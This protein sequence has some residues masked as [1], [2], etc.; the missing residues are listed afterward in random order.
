MVSPRSVTPS[1]LTSLTVA[2]FTIEMPLDWAT[3]VEVDEGGEVIGGPEGGVP[4]PVAVLLT[5]PAS[6]SVWVMVCTV[7]AVQVSAA[8]GA[9][10][11][12]GQVVAPAMGSVTLTEVSVTV[13]VLVTR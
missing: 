5:T 10:V 8:P 1:A 11:E 9:S 2:D 7:L 4:V 13:P 3:G 12:L 6:T